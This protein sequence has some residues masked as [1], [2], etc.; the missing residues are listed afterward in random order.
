MTYYQ[1]GAY[2]ISAD[3]PFRLLQV[4]ISLSLRFKGLFLYFLYTSGVLLH[5]G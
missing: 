2:T 1:L 3:P 4:S 5:M